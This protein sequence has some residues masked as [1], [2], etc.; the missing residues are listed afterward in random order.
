MTND[1]SNNSSS[2][3]KPVAALN[4]YKKVAIIRGSDDV[5]TYEDAEGS[6]KTITDLHLAAVATVRKNHL[7]FV[8]FVVWLQ[9]RIVLT[10][11]PEHFSRSYSDATT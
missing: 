11:F 2:N 4:V 9:F 5:L 3:S 6:I 8:I 1:N 10:F 7:I